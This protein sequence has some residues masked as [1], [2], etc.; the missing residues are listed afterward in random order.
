MALTEL[1]KSR[2]ANN[3]KDIKQSTGW[4]FIR[5]LATAEAAQDNPDFHGLKL[6]ILTMLDAALEEE[7]NNGLERQKK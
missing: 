5:Q 3:L 6:D 1:Q 4:R 2:L 7:F